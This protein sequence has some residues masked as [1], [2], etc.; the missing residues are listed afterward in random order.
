M[1]IRL[2][3][4]GLV[5]ATVGR[6]DYASPYL[7]PILTRP[8]ELVTAGAARLPIVCLCFSEEKLAVARCVKNPC[9]KNTMIVFVSVPCA[10]FATRVLIRAAGQSIFLLGHEL[11]VWLRLAV[12]SR[13][14]SCA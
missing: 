14:G 7:A 13:L 2:F 9:R 12:K 8:L 1:N 10:L 3:R 5:R 11:R 6:S 4:S